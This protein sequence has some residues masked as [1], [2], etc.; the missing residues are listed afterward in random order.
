MMR[1]TILTT[2]AFQMDI[3]SKGMFFIAFPQVPGKRNEPMLSWTEIVQNYITKHS[4]QIRKTTQP[5]RQLFGIGYFTY[6]RIDSKGKYTVLVDRPDWAE[7]Y[8]SEQIFQNDPFLRDYSMYESGICVMD[9]H[10]SREHQEKLLSSAKQVLNLDL[11]VMFIQKQATCAEFFGFC[12]SKR[13][14]SLEMLYVN[15]P[16]LLH[17]FCTHFKKQFTPLLTQMEDEASSLIDL[18]GRDFFCKEPIC[19]KVAPDTIQDYY[20]TIGKQAEVEHAGKLSARERECLR[21][22]I[23]GKSAKETAMLLGLS[24]RTIEFYFENIKDKLACWSKQEVFQ[25]AKTLADLGL[26]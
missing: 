10:G 3:L 18:K 9:K 2:R 23:E 22:L 15:H 4:D 21:L 25:I 24:R 6:H 8:V 12:G 1:Q 7:H 19:Q 13:A 5:L 16:G 11:G 14:S 20:K 17:S 26:L